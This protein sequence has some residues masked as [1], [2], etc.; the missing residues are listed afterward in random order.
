MSLVFC[1]W[2]GSWWLCS[3]KRERKRLVASFTCHRSA[4]RAKTMRLVRSPRWESGPGE[5]TGA[6]DSSSRSLPAEPSRPSA[7]LDEDWLSPSAGWNEWVIPTKVVPL[8]ILCST[9]KSLCSDFAIA[10]PSAYAANPKA[11]AR[12][13]Q[14]PPPWPLVLSPHEPYNATAFALAPDKQHGIEMWALAH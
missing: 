1:S 5:T 11:E 14:V 4:L 2:F 9:I 8:K 12:Q 6:G 13:P 10:I 7:G 3:G